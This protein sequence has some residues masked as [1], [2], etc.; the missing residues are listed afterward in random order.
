M[1]DYKQAS[2]TGTAWQRC[3]QIVIEN[4]RGAAPTV[5]FDEQEV[6]ARSDSREILTPIGSLALPF[7][8]S[9]EIPLRDPATGEL[10]G[11]SSSYGAAYVLL[12]S[13]YLDAAHARDEAL[14]PPA[15]EMPPAP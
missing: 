4:P 12:Y 1:P 11:A 8:P 13:A 14:I 6:L 2:L 3:H 9:K 5:R 7:D 15:V 10:T